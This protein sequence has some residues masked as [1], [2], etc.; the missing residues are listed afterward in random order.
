VCGETR[1]KVVES[2]EKSKESKVDISV[3]VNDSLY[4]AGNRRVDRSKGVDRRVRKMG[5]FKECESN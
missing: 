4:L 5:R 3:R 2:I 1:L